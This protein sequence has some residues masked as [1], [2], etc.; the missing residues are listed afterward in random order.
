MIFH[1][2]MWTNFVYCILAIHLFL[3]SPVNLTSHFSNF[4][5]FRKLQIPNAHTKYYEI[6][7]APTKTPHNTTHKIAS[8]YF[9][10]EYLFL[11]LQKKFRLLWNKGVCNQCSNIFWI[12]PRWLDMV[13]WNSAPCYILFV[14]LCISSWRMVPKIDSLIYIYLHC[15]IKTI[16]VLFRF[17][18][19][20][21]VLEYSQV[22]HV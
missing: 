15:S 13:Q 2:L 17:L 9:E 4:A 22:L 11:I 18:L 10:F 7:P 21:L 6:I 20:L 12:I 1:R 14:W 8:L 19:W 3:S 5:Y 16:Y